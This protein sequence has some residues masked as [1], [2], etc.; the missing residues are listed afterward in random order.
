MNDDII[1]PAWT[2][3]RFGRLKVMGQL[4]TI[5]K[6]TWYLCKCDCGQKLR[7]TFGE[8]NMGLRTGC[9]KCGPEPESEIEPNTAREA[10][11]W[12]FCA[13]VKRGLVNQLQT[14]KSEL[15]RWWWTSLN[16]IVDEMTQMLGRNTYTDLEI[17][18][19]FECPVKAV[20]AVRR[21]YTARIR[22]INREY[23]AVQK[24][25]AHIPKVPSE[26]FCDRD[27]ATLLSLALSHRSSR[28]RYVGRSNLYGD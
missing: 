6:E 20:D 4:H 23:K 2:G 27:V 15:P 9:D 24:Q 13:T 1:R 12:S 22:Q 21:F 16:V 17:A 18:D 5:D 14:M 3:K 19:F 10:D 28:I 8:L 26:M 11:T 25:F 7:C